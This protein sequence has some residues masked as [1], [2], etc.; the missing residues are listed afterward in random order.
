TDLFLVSSEKEKDIVVQDYGHESSKVKITGLSRFD[1]LF[2]KDI[3]I[4]RQVLIIPTWR[5]GLINDQRFLKSKY[6]HRYL[7][8]VFHPQ[9]LKLATENHFNIVFCLHP[10]MQ[11]FSG[12]FKDA[13][14]VK[15]IDQ[16]E[17]DVQHLLKESAMLI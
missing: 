3:E 13:K 7:E 4:K 11:R 17:A 1:N 12:Y 6:F 14:S 15:V 5:N 10:N 8:L 9:L 16:G 2:E